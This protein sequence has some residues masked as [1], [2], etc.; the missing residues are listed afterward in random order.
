MNFIDWHRNLRII[1]RYEKKEYIL[2]EVLPN[3]P[4]NKAEKSV[5]EKYNKF[6]DDE[7]VVSYL[8]VTTMSSEL[9]KRFETRGAFDIM[10]QLKKIFQEKAQTEICVRPFFARSAPPL[11]DGMRKKDTEIPPKRA[12]V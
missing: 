11:G 10:D 9:Q 6:I 7:L 2:T 1:L 3:K 4:S 8:M 5:R 12:S